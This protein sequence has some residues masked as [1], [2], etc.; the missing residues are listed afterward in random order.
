MASF[1]GPFFGPFFGETSTQ[2]FTG[3]TR[4]EAM[5]R[6]M[7]GFC[8]PCCGKGKVPCCDNPM[9]TSISWAITGISGIAACLSGTAVFADLV[10]PCTPPVVDGN[11]V[12]DA[13]GDCLLEA[14][15][16][17][18]FR[19]GPP[20]NAS[21]GSFGIIAYCKLG[22]TET[23]LRLT[24]CCV[25]PPDD[26]PEPFEP[27][28]RLGA[29]YSSGDGVTTVQAQWCTEDFDVSNCDP[30]ILEVLSIPALFSEGIPGTPTLTVVLS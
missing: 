25:E 2:S 13:S 21:L 1:F 8:K 27:R 30:F 3:R 20:A 4:E 24:I 19:C 17:N 12:C 28:Y 9:P 16:L 29:Y 26:D 5:I 22:D 15:D 10:D 18:G 11:F 14:D 23:Q 7:M 6:A